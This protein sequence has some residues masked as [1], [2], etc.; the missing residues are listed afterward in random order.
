MAKHTP[1]NNNTQE[2]PTDRRC[3]ATNRQ[4]KQCGRWA[5][6]GATVCASHGG[7]SPQVLNAAKKKEARRKA[8]ADAN[9]VL[10]H[11]GLTPVTDPILALATLAQETI[12]FKDALAA[13]INALSDVTTTNAFGQERINVVVELYERALDRTIRALDMLGKHDLEDRRVRVEE[14]TAAM[15]AYIMRGVMGELGLSQEQRER[16]DSTV[17]VWVRRS[18]EGVPANELPRG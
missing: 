11:E 13:R 16:V 8:I 6:K 3:T 18:L 1:W 17:E 15:F 5:I 9:A 2:N 10:A 12:G 14:H 7:K 4:G